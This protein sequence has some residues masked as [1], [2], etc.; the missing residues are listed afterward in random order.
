MKILFV[1]FNFIKK[2]A[3]MKGVSKHKFF[4]LISIILFLMTLS[5]CGPGKKLKDYDCGCWSHNTEVKSQAH[6]KKQKS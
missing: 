3:V 6:A 1:Y 4:A 2:I 5:S